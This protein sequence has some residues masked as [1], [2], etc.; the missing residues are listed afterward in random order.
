MSPIESASLMPIVA[1]LELDIYQLR[2]HRV[3]KGS[4][5]L[6]SVVRMPLN[7]FVLRQ[8]WRSAASH[9]KVATGDSLEKRLE[10]G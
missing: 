8:P 3:G 9:D 7:R 10:V 1:L 4:L 2:L 6:G 5:T